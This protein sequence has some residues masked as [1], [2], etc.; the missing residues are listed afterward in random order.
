[1][2]DIGPTFRRFSKGPWKSE[3]PGGVA[4]GHHVPLLAPF[5]WGPG[6]LH[7][8]EGF[9]ALSR[10][11]VIAREICLDLL[12][13]AACMGHGGLLALRGPLRPKATALVIVETALTRSAPTS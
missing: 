6:R 7:W 10:H 3:G 12:H 9:R 2:F 13:G 8:P 1:M 4:L 5:H 11:G